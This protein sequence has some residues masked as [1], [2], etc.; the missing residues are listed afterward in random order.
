ML[1]NT[2][3]KKSKFIREPD[4][5]EIYEMPEYFAMSKEEISNHPTC[6]PALRRII[7]DFPWISRKTV[8]QVR[9]Q[10][11]RKAKPELLGDHWHV[12]VNVRLKDEKVRVAKSMDDFR[13]LVVSFG[14]VCG[15]EFI[16]TQME[17]EDITLPHFD[18]GKFF[19]EVNRMKFDIFRAE[20]GQVIEYTS[21]DMHRMSPNFRIGRLR[22]MIV[23]FECDEVEA[24][25]WV[26][27]SIM[28]KDTGNGMK[29]EDYTI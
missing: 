23:A 29:L 5:D 19:D 10:D 3:Y 6:T 20:Q 15:T 26:L 24:D 12:D 13:L 25:G 22:L 1:F 9:P 7:G 18:H 4:Q 14:D 21:R 8:L 27:P 16:A 17:L 28:E 2:G 11:F